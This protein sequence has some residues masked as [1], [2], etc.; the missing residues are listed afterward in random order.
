[1]LAVLLDTSGHLKNDVKYD[2]ITAEY[3]QVPSVEHLACGRAREFK[4]EAAA[5]RQAVGR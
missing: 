4:N 2:N 5:I 1:M 3:F